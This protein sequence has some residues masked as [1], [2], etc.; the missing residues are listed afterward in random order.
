MNYTLDELKH[1][2]LRGNR[3]KPGAILKLLKSND[4]KA[5][6]VS[7]ESYDQRILFLCLDLPQVMEHIEYFD[8]PDTMD[9]KLNTYLREYFNVKVEVDTINEELLMPDIFQTYGSDFG[10]KE[11][12]LEFISKYFDNSEYD[13]QEVGKSLSIK[14]MN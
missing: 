5:E 7:E 13:I 1:G 2:V 9:N 8:N 11:V 10:S 4:P 12:I 3:K 6:F 14:F